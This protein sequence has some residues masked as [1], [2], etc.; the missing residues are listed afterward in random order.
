MNKASISE[1]GCV[2]VLASAPSN[3]ATSL[4]Q[5]QQISTQAE[6]STGLPQQRNTR[7]FS[8]KTYSPLTSPILDH[9]PSTKSDRSKLEIINLTSPETVESFI[10]L[11]K[12]ELPTLDTVPSQPT[13]CNPAEDKALNSDPAVTHRVKTTTS[14]SLLE[15]FFSD[16]AAPG[17]EDYPQPEDFEMERS[18]PSSYTRSRKSSNAQSSPTSVSS[19]ANTVGGKLGWFRSRAASNGSRKSP[20]S[21][22][23]MSPTALQ[24]RHEDSELTAADPL[25]NLDIESS[26]FPDGPA[27]PLDPASFITLLTHATCLIETLQTAYKARTTAL[28]DLRADYAAQTDEL[29]ETET[30]ARHL[31][32]QLS[33]MSSRMA[34]TE[35]SLRS[36]L[37]EER[38]K[39]EELELRDKDKAAK[40]RTNSRNNMRSN[41]S[42]SGF[43][44]DTD[45]E[46]TT[47]LLD[48]DVEAEKQSTVALRTSDTDA[49]FRALCLDTRAVLE[50]DKLLSNPSTTETLWER[51][52]TTGPSALLSENWILR[53]RVLELETTVDTCLGLL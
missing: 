35:T 44:S 42:D 48:P 41:A 5:Q 29:D 46:Y 4:D 34:D 28:C 24:Q 11:S 7:N 33:D 40:R 47:M 43:E 22:K 20:K 13:I 9:H 27:D 49:E 3:A 25:F 38:K 36:Q 30:R 12:P 18:S 51:R 10:E 1:L 37:V 32:M 16:Y 45:P 23:D 6:H 53:R 39:R 2:L 19:F 26:L 14:K 52:S 8:R 15:S 50:K 17:P 31:K 21:V